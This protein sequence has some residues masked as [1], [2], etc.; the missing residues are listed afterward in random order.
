MK[1]IK[2]VREIEGEIESKIKEI[3]GVKD[4]RVKIVMEEKGQLRRGE[5]KKYEQVVISEEGG[6]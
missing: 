5:K 6:F 1:E 4:E 3:R 2:S